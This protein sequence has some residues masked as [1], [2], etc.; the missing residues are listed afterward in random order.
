MSLDQDLQSLS[1]NRG[2]VEGDTGESTASP[3]SSSQ[4]PA[5]EEEGLQYSQYEPTGW[6][7]VELSG[8][9][10]VAIARLFGGRTH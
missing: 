2:R 4:S 5:N 7:E 1:L 6:V 8:Q 3:A 10:A 9:S